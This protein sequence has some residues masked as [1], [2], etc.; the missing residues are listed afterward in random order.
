MGGK[1]GIVISHDQLSPEA[2][3]GVIEDFISRE[4]TDYGEVEVSLETKIAQVLNQLKSR[5]A[6]IVFDPDSETCTILRKD[7]PALKQIDS[8]NF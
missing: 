7:D 6:T 8:L 5:K 4:G 3:Q 1:T 2:L